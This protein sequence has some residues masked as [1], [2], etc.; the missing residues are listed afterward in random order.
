MQITDDKKRRIYL[1][2]TTA[3]TVVDLISIVFAAIIV[4]TVYRVPVLLWNIYKKG[5]GSIKKILSGQ[6]NLIIADVTAV[7]QILTIIYTLFNLYNAACR[8][9]RSYIYAFRKWQKQKS[10]K[11]LGPKKVVT[12]DNGWILPEEI[13]ASAFVYLHPA[14]LSAS[15]KVCK[16]WH[17]V[18]N[19]NYLWE[20]YV[21]HDDV[22]TA[23]R[24]QNETFTGIVYS[25]FAANHYKQ[26]YI[27]RHLERTPKKCKYIQ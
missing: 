4:V 9:I 8:F 6:V 24:N 11:A 17:D 2:Q 14:K 27:K 3:S 23:H 20:F 10:Y 18:A 15:S 5:F 21:T 1:T 12:A 25:A 19:K 22:L 7:I 26:T 16:Y 13:L